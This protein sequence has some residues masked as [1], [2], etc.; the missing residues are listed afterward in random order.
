MIAVATVVTASVVSEQ[1]NTVPYDYRKLTID[2]REEVLRRRR[3]LGYP[4]HAPPHPF[5]DA[6]RYLISAATFEHTPIMTPPDRRSD[7]ESKLL[8]VM[9]GVHAEVYA[10]VV[11]PNHYHILLGVDALDLVSAALKKLHGAT[12]R[13]WNLADGQTGERHVWYKF[14]DRMI[15]NDA[16]FFR[17][18]NYVHYNPVKHRYTVNPYEWPWSS[19]TNYLDA[20]GREWLRA[21]WKAYPPDDNFG[22]DWDD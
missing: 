17:S 5:R 10:W 19:L 14:A 7:F 8:A 18:L 3:E 12:S 15:R 22:K 13:E 11:L 4:L 6:G 20:R 2:E 21:A 1:A 16:H 9:E